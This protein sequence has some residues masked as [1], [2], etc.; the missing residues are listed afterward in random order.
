MV[1]VTVVVVILQ[2]EVL[3]CAVGS[4][5]NGRDAQTGEE[6]LETVPPAEGAGI[7]PGLT[8]GRFST[9]RN[10]SHSGDKSTY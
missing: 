7:A 3:V 2:E 10:W 6:T 8:V 4:E 9:E 1:G 5:G